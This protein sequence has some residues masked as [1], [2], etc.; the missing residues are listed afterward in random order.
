MLRLQG[1]ATTIDKLRGEL[2]ATTKQ[3]R[4]KIGQWI[5]KK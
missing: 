3:P 4:N 2:G 5:A 1:K